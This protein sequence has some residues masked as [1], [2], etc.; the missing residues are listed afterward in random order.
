MKSLLVSVIIFLLVSACAKQEKETQSKDSQKG[1]QKY[2]K[3]RERTVSFGYDN[4][5]ISYKKTNDNNFLFYIKVDPQK[6][7]TKEEAE[8]NV[9]YY[10]LKVNPQ[11]DTISSIPVSFEYHLGNY[12]ESEDSYYVITTALLNGGKYT[13]DFLNRYDKHWKLIWSRRIDKPKRADISTVLTLTPNKELLVIGN[14]WN[15]KYKMNGLTI[16]RFTLDG[17]MLTEK[18]IPAEKRSNP[19]SLIPS[20]D[21]TYF[22]TTWK[23]HPT[24]KYPYNLLWLLK[25]NQQGDTLW[26]KTYTDLYPGPTLLTCK[27]DLVCYGRQ[28]V[29]PYGQDIYSFKVVVL[30]QTGNIKWQKVFFRHAYLGTGDIVESS[31]GNYL[32]TG[33]VHPLATS[34]GS[35]SLFE[36]NKKGDLVYQKE[37]E[38]DYIRDGVPFLVESEKQLLLITEDQIDRFKKDSDPYHHIIRIT[39]ISE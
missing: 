30:D 34:E 18:F 19:V 5:I 37:F 3:I 31:N 25:L 36:L 11:G 1:K 22:L 32:F 38:Y 23:Y 29:S 20:A 12:V 28:I 17:K 14:Q 24:Y 6:V 15:R 39:S 13:R 9:R 35:G 26:T 33:V 7:N 16:M 2:Q 4:D 10:F 27:G 8:R 21:G